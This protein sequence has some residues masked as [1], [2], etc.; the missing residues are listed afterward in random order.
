MQCKVCEFGC[1]INEYS[2]GRCG[3][4]VHTGNTIIQDPDIGYMG[5]YP[6][7]IETI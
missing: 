2:R 5:A 6:V 4:Y 3:T 1:E 7:S